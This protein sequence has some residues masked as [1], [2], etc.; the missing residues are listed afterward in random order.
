MVSGEEYTLE[1]Y[2]LRN[3]EMQCG[4]DARWFEPK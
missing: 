4:N 2:Q 3:D 1:C